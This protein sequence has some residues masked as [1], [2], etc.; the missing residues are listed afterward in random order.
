MLKL[1]LSSPHMSMTISKNQNEKNVKN[2]PKSQS[3]MDILSILREALKIIIG[4]G[5]VIVSIF[6]PVFI[7]YSM[8]PYGV[9][10]VSL[11]LMK[12]LMWRWS[13]FNDYHEE[14]KFDQFWQSGIT[15]DI[16]RLLVLQSVKWFFSCVIMLFILVTTVSLASEAY[17]GKKL[18]MKDAFPMIKGRWRRPVI[19]S[20]YIAIISLSLIVVFSTITMLIPLMVDGFLCFGLLA[21][22]AIL[23]AIGYIYVD[24]VWMLSLVVSILEDDSC[25]LKAIVRAGELIKGKRLKGCVINLLLVTTS[26]IV[27]ITFLKTINSNLTAQEVL[28]VLIPHAFA[29]CL[30]KFLMFVM[31]TVFYHECKLSHEEARVKGELGLYAPIASVEA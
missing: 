7:S 28:I 24:A 10:L 4:N 30:L 6:L 19:T 13:F 9:N 2:P 8:L 5:T 22:V 15:K 3:S 29:N 14:N 26:V 16:K 21:V 12:D 25:G 23:G 11:P 31:F 20:I 27:G 18:S 17:T 1:S